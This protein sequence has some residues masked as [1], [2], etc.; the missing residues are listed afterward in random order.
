[1]TCLNIANTIYY[2]I[3]FI[4][5]LTIFWYNK[6]HSTIGKPYLAIIASNG[7]GIFLL[8]WRLKLWVDFTVCSAFFNKR[9]DTIIAKSNF[10]TSVSLLFTASSFLYLISLLSSAILELKIHVVKYL[11]GNVVNLRAYGRIHYPGVCSF[12]WNFE[13]THKNLEFRHHRMWS[14]NRQLQ[15]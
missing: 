13:W 15:C 11:W 9:W 3:L 10:L 6:A 7:L 1:M 8:L 5:T 14:L 2:A 12:C 4:D